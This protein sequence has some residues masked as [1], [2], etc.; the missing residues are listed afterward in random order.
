MTGAYKL[1]ILIPPLI[2][3]VCYILF[4]PT[5]SGNIESGFSFFLIEEFTAFIYRTLNIRDAHQSCSRTV[6]FASALYSYPV[7]TIYLLYKLHFKISGA[8]Y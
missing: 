5:C 8:Y 1:L 7:S 4:P 6:T 2:H 3:S